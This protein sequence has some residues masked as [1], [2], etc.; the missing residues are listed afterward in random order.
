MDDR[1]QFDPYHKW[2]GIPSHE[3]PPNHY[4]LLR[5]ELFE[6]DPDVIDH[7]YDKEMG[8]LKQQEHGAHAAFVEPLSREF[9]VARQCLLD[10]EK[11]AAYDAVLRANIDAL[12]KTQVAGEASS[13]AADTPS[14]R[15]PRFYAP[16]MAIDRGLLKLVGGKSAV[17][18]WVAR[19]AMLLLL[20]G[21][22]AAIAWLVG[23]QMRAPSPSSSTVAMN[24]PGANKTAPSESEQPQHPSSLEA[25]PT[26]VPE[27]DPLSTEPSTDAGVESGV[28]PEFAAIKWVWEVGGRVGF[29]VD[30]RP[31]YPKTATEVPEPQHRIHFIAVMHSK[32]VNDA[33][34]VALKGLIGVHTI[35]LMNTNIS[36]NAIPTLKQL[37]SLRMIELR[38]TKVSDA[39]VAELKAALPNCRVSHG[40]SM[41]ARSRA[42]PTGRR[43][44]KS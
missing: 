28:H 41:G 7:A 29:L 21:G 26:K 3:Q 8:H 6:A 13:Q 31:V 36:D 15:G 9:V 44:P 27:E 22:I 33:G 18:H 11:K 30:G 25:S 24:A 43:P 42:R 20:L 40:A 16:L 5:I 39:G 2:L 1:D 32:K 19:S 35:V 12:N 4:R 38:G 37:T 10:S 23:Q 14:Q 34:I 17:L